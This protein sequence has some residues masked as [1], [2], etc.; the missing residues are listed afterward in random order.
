M[1]SLRD[2]QLTTL[3]M[4]GKSYS[5]EM[6]IKKHHHDFY[7]LQYLVSGS[8]DLTID[9]VQHSLKPNYIAML[10]S[11][12]SH[13]Y[14]FNR[15]SKI[16]DIKF[17]MVDALRDLLS[18]LFQNPVF[19]I[20]DEM[21]RAHFSQLIDQG[22]YYQQFKQAKVL[23]N[24]DTQIKLLLLELLTPTVPEPIPLQKSP[25]IFN[26][27]DNDVD[28]DMLRYMETNF[29]Q[30]L[31]LDMISK[32]FHYSK[33]EIINIFSEKLHQTPIHVLQRIRL[34]HAKS[35]LSETDLPI[36]QIANEVG[37]NDNYFTK[38]FLKYENQL[39][40]EYRLIKNRKTDEIVLNTSFDI[41]TQP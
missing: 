19:L 12:V 3:W 1:K 21:I 31:T 17:S 30:K 28:F 40:S 14:S 22:I 9:N 16:I 2:D 10:D 4:S 38:A 11:N 33:A 34:Q 39:P 41:T 36:G 32:K 6:L 5:K 8:E 20:N 15:D 26:S 13:S 35:L 37:F 29:N 23:I 25:S 27:Q 18:S 7:Q 24:I